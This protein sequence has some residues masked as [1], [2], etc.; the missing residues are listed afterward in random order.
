MKATEMQKI[1]PANATNILEGAISTNQ[2]ESS[3]SC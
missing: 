1:E 2:I 3:S